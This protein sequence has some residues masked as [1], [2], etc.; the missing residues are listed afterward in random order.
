MSLK[1]TI[2]LLNRPEKHFLESY[3]YRKVKAGIDAAVAGT[4]YT[5]VPA[6]QDTRLPENVSEDNLDNSG[7][8]AIAPHVHNPSIVELEKSNIPAVLVNCRSERIAW[9][10]TDNVLGAATMTE[11][12]ITLGHKKIALV[13]GFPDSQNGIDRLHGYKQ[14]LEKNNIQFDPK[15]IINCDFSV[16]LAYERV[17]AYLA[18]NKGADFTAV[19]STNDYM[20][21]GVIRALTDEKIRVPEN[22]GVVGFDD[23]DFASTFYV[24]LTTYRQPFDNLGFAATKFL[25]KQMRGKAEK[26]LQAEFMGELIVR[27]SCGSKYRK[28]GS[29]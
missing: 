19:F 9:V 28:S 12:L 8:L 16:T 25:I 3:Y 6:Q 13:N 10:D 15:M 11:Y 24:P 7:V 26:N 29:F 21:V 5:I 20:A 18:Q 2:I 14:A 22:V 1:N 23:L 17:K 27:D 4:E